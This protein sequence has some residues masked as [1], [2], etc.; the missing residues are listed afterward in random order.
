MSGENP[1]HHQSDCVKPTPGHRR[2]SPRHLDAVRTRMEIG[3]HDTSDVQREVVRKMMEDLSQADVAE[4]DE[5]HT[6]S[7][8][9]E[10]IGE[11]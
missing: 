8:P 4:G 3:Y 7:H 9:T 2:F 5:R 1:H 10:V 11:F 6:S